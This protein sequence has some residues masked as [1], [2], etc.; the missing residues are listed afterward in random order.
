VLSQVYQELR[1][2]AA[3]KMASESP[4]QTLQPTAL[5]HETWLL[6]FG[7]DALYCPDPAYFF[8]AAGKAM[9]RILVERARASCGPDFSIKCTVTR[10]GR[11]T[12]GWRSRFF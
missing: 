4:D 1:R 7:G 5:V 2:L 3:Y 10:I 12:E 9:R 11:Y 6:L 8:A